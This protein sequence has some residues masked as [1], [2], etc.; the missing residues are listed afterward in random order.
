[1]GHIPY[2][3]IKVVS[4]D[5]FGCTSGCIADGATNFLMIIG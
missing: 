4:I 1:M 2:G 3:A 5:E